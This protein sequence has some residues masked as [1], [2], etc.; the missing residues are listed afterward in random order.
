MSQTRDPSRQEIGG[1]QRVRAV[2]TAVADAEGVDPTELAPLYHAVGA[3]TVDAL[4][5]SS[6]RADGGTPGL[7]RFT[8]HGHR[9]RVSAD[10]EVTLGDR[11]GN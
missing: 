10:G 3:G 6:A 1:E 4:L 9:V 2:V 7:I 5:R 11:S 8:Y